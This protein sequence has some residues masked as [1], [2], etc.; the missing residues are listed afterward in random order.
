MCYDRG[1]GTFT[2][3][4]TALPLPTV[5]ELAFFLI[6]FIGFLSA[7]IAGELWGDKKVTL[8]IYDKSA[9]VFYALSANKNDGYSYKKTVLAKGPQ[10]A[11]LAASL[12]K[13]DV[14]FMVKE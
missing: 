2:T 9:K 6:P 3:T 11:T 14:K 12:R 10:S 7:L 1:G 13:L 5:T 4:I 8:F